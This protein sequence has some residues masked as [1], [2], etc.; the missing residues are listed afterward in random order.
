M[1]REEDVVFL[2]GSGAVSGSWAPVISGL[3]DFGFH[4]VRSPSGANFAMAQLAYTARIAWLGDSSELVDARSP[5]LEKLSAGRQAVAAAL[6]IAEEMG[7][8]AVRREFHDVVRHVVLPSA[9]SLTL[10][11]TNWDQTVELAAEKQVAGIKALYVHGRSSDARHM[12][13]P[14]EI[15]EEPF[16]S[17]SERAALSD[18]RSELVN[19]IGQATRLVL[20]GLALSALDIELGHIVAAGLHDGRVRE[21]QVVDPNYASVAERLGTFGK[22]GSSD[23]PVVCR[24]PS[25]LSEQWRFEPGDLERVLNEQSSCR[26]V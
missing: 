23:L 13:L 19:A 16:R 25:A 12:Y 8:L 3:R 9:D 20:Y 18:A 2:V 10:V 15:V 14:T 21:I 24:S 26:S 11:T 17:P 22:I 7:R 1:S 5:F 4:D 6:L